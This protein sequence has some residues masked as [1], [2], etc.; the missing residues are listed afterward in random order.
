MGGSEN[1][2]ELTDLALPLHIHPPLHNG[3]LVVDC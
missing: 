3:P 1:V 2:N